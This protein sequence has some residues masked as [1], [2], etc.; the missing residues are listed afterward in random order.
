VLAEA[1]G[2]IL[3]RRQVRDPTS[4]KRRRL[5]V[6]HVPEAIDRYWMN[7]EDKVNADRPPN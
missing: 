2:K 1:L 7:N 4:S 6:Y 3:S 5:T